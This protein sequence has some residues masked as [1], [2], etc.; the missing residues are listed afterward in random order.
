MRRLVL[1]A[2]I[3]LG[4]FCGAVWSAGEPARTVVIRAGKIWTMAGRVVSDGVVVVRDGKIRAVRD[5]S[6]AP[7]EAEVLDMSDKHVMPGLIDAH[8]HIGLSLNPLNEINE[9]VHA[10]TP[11]M[12]IVDAFDPTSEDLRKAVRWGVTAVMLAPGDRNPVGGQTA[13]VKLHGREIS[14]WLVKEACGIKMSLTNEALMHDR[15][16]TSRAGLLRMLRD[17]FDRADQYDD[18]GVSDTSLDVLQKAIHGELPVYMTARSAD[19]VQAGLRLIEQYDLKAVLVD[20]A[21]TEE[22][23]AKISE[24]GIG[25]IHGPMLRLS[26]NREL[27]RFGVLAQKDVKLAFASHGPRSS[28]HDLR[29]SAVI[30]TKHGLDPNEALKAL[31][32]NAAE[33]LGVAKRLGSIE[34]GKDA[35]LV[36]FSGHPLEQTS[37]VEMVMINGVVVY[38]RQDI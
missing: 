8:C 10:V 23:A 11:Q 28:L 37:A 26:R 30:A 2:V 5:N 12:Q 13:V 32:I 6:S 29:T 22:A 1:S 38:R 15:A 4:A 3:V 33:L 7:G 19:E 25:I 16:P 27:K 17:E 34:R 24:R 21:E 20:V 31:T 35:D 36:I 9:T 18:E 14:Q